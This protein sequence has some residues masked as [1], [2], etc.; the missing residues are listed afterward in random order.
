V[1]IFILKLLF[2]KLFATIL[3]NNMSLVRDCEPAII[4]YSAG[5]LVDIEALRSLHKNRLAIL[6]VEITH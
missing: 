6:V 5:L 2:I 1:Q 4:A 3:V